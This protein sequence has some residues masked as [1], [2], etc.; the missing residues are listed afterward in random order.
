MN[1]LLDI[2]HGDFGR[3]TDLQ[4]VIDSAAK[5]YLMLCLAECAV[6]DASAA[7]IARYMDQHPDVDLLYADYTADGRICRLGEYEAGSFRDDFDFGPMVVLRVA[8]ARA[9]KLEQELRYSALY[10][11]RLALTPRIAHLAEPLSSISGDGRQL[12]Q[13]AY[14]ADERQ[15]QQ[16]EAEQVFTRFLHERGAFIRPNQ[17]RQVD[18]AA[19]RDMP[20][21]ITVVIPVLN[22]A[23]TIE[24]AIR[25][26]AGQCTDFTYNIVVV[27]NHST[28]GTT[29]IIRRL[30][31]ADS[32][33]IHIVPQQTGLGIGGCWNRAIHDPRCGRY[34]VQL[35]SD[36]L[37]SGPDV[38]SRIHSTF[39]RDRVAAVVGSYTLTDMQGRVLP[40]G[41]I[42]HREWT[43]ENGHNNLLRVNGAGAPRAFCVPTL[44]AIGGF[45]DV[46]YGEDYAVMLRLSREYRIS[47]IYDSLY[48]CRRWEGNSDAGLSRE[49]LNRFNAYK[50]RLR[51]EEFR[52]RIN[53]NTHR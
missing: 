1:S 9:V 40:P 19:G 23:R 22:R 32:R 53:I 34:A 20:T 6:D 25:S 24:D 35:D 39:L 8:A 27:D 41:L 43:D 42:C 11:L 49:T 36:D 45:P 37:Y 46:S 50:D 15:L 44:L 21:E 30:A 48:L 10:S 17:L 26:A 47:R 31:A 5:P 12:S 38:L 7:L 2:Q 14:Q 3:T 13:F 18:T 52:E 4:R 16:R 51:G 29:D 33:I 28:D